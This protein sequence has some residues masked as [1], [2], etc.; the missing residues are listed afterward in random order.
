[1][2]PLFLKKLR[3]HTG[4]LRRFAAWSVRVIRS[5]IPFAFAFHLDVCQRYIE[6]YISLQRL[7]TVP[8]NHLSA[9]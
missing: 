4:F 2:R 6:M 8:N 3:S 5:Y 1:M 7:F 9:G